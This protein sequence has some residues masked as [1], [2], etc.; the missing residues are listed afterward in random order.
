MKLMIDPQYW[1]L[2]RAAG[3][4]LV[5]TIVATLPGFMMFWL[6]R[7]HKG[8]LPRSHAH[9]VFERSSILSGV[10]LIAIGFMLLQTAFQN[11]DGA[12]LANIGATAFF[13]GGILAVAAEAL[14]L[15]LGYEKVYGLIVIYV[16]M[17]FLAEAAIGGAV[18]QSGL[19]AAWIGWLMILWNIGWLVMLP[20][21][22]RRDMYFPILHYLMPLVIGIALLM[23]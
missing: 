9:W 14:M 3:L 4:F 7:G 17:A 11:T 2:E 12:I 20:I 1:N 5:L 10:I 16:V 6:R 22:S 13:F 19:L 23:K 21:V 8:G 15:T 18:I